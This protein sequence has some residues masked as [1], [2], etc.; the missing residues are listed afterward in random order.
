MSDVRRGVATDP[1][2]SVVLPC[3]NEEETLAHCVGQAQRAFA[4]LGVRG[5]VVVADNGSTDRSAEIA[6]RLGA[7]VVRE[8]VRG[9]GAALMAGFEAADAEFIVM[10]DA[11]GSYDF[12]SIGPFLDKLRSGYDLVLGN[13][14]AGGIRKGAMSVLHR[15]FGN[16]V[17]SFL[18]RSISRAP[19]GDF[20]CGLRALSKTAYRSMGLRTRGMEFATEMVVAAAKQGLRITEVPT[21]LH[22]DRRSRPPHLRSFRDGW[23]HLRFIVT[24]A[25]DHVY[26]VP[27]V[28]LFLAGMVLQ[29]A[30]VAGPI[31]VGGMTL[32]IHFVALGGL[33]A[34][35]GVNILMLGVLAKLAIAQMYPNLSSRTARWVLTRFRLEWGLAAGT[36]LILLGAAVDVVIFVRWVG[37]GRGPLDDTVHAAFVATTAMVIG[38]SLIFFAFLL[39]LFRLADREREAAPAREPR[40]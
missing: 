20:H 4:A 10:G 35:V 36:V 37:S 23:R 21:V 13:R 5:Q 19:V 2:V 9:Y 17:L 1:D 27:G 8:P 28:V 3:L 33:L 31:D 16:P 15:Y 7:K 24:C 6:R 29:T 26:A 40:T 22:P 34:L 30:L 38:I 18:G 25:P 32:G 39:N 14:F 12:G 11:D